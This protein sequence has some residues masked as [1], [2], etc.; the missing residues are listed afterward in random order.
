MNIPRKL[1][2][3]DALA[4]KFILAG[5]LKKLAGISRNCRG[6]VLF[7]PA[8]ESEVRFSPS[9]FIDF[10]PRDPRNSIWLSIFQTEYVTRI[11]GRAWYTPESSYARNVI[12]ND[13][14]T[15]T[16]R[17][18]ASIVMISESLS[19]LLRHVCQIF[20]P[21]MNLFVISPAFVSIIREIPPI[22]SFHRETLQLS[23]IVQDDL[24]LKPL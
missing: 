21:L 5:N 23:V 16:A 22:L 24:T 11:A 15:A 1:G 6:S 17:R 10:I 20:P 4:A 14:I 19:A 13:G 9:G 8:I 12:N 7:N 3:T 18:A 2:C